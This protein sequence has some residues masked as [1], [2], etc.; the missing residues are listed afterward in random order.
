MLSETIPSGGRLRLHHEGVQ[1][2]AADV[3]WSGDDLDALVEKIGEFVVVSQTSK[4][5]VLVGD[6]HVD[7]VQ[8][9]SWMGHWP[10]LEDATKGSWE[11]NANFGLGFP[12][13]ASEMHGWRDVLLTSTIVCLFTGESHP[14]DIAANANQA[15]IEL[16]ETA[17]QRFVAGAGYTQYIPRPEKALGYRTLPVDQSIYGIVAAIKSMGEHRIAARLEYLASDALLDDGDVP[18]SLPACAGFWDFYSKYTGDAY[19]NLTCAKGWLCT[20]WDF[21]DG[22]SVVLWFYDFDSA[23]VTVFDNEGNI[24]D[25]NT[26]RRVR[27]RRTIMSNLDQA[28]YFSWRNMHSTEENSRPMT[29][30]PA[31]ALRRSSETMD[32]HL[33]PLL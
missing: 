6:S 7:V 33:R 12:S 19:L 17:R 14:G 25:V 5:D 24:V 27:D 4:Y 32:D 10:P 26:D 16:V 28:G 13:N 9:P 15:S 20:E 2:L 8:L 22:S 18:V 23:R 30:S 29:I 1:A 21:P 31:I 3:K 11:L